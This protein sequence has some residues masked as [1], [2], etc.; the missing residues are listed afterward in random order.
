MLVKIGSYTLCDG[1]LTGGVAISDLRVNQTRTVDTAVV[2][3]TGLSGSGTQSDRVSIVNYDRDCRPCA[4][5][6]EVK[7]IH[8]SVD[9]AE[10]FILELDD[11][12]PY[13]DT[14]TVTVTTTGPSE[15][16]FV[17]PNAK[18]QTHELLQQ[19]GSM[20]VHSYTLIGGPKTI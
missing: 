5:S 18:V 15:D 4:Y 11:S 16:S 13:L 19:L 17:I 14:A 1:T 20:T 10:Q 7:R 3:A 6:F 12:I 9:A 8:S 2:L